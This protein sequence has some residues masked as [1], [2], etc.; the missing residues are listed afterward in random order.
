MRIEKRKGVEAIQAPTAEEFN[1]RIN[2][3]L[4]REKNAN[5]TFITSGGMLGAYVEYETEIEIPES[6]AEKYELNG[7][8]RKCHECPYFIRT[9]DKRYKWHFCVQK[10]KKVTECQGAC[11]TYY[12]LLED[13]IENGLKEAV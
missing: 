13:L 6:L 2:A 10:Q 11:E 5:V 1:E 3:V 9:K 4:K 7:D 8:T 12:Q